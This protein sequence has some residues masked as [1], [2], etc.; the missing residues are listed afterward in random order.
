MA[1]FWDVVPCSLV[2]ILVFQRSLLPPPLPWWWR[3][4]APLKRDSVLT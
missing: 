2:D 4:E 3:Q 1:V